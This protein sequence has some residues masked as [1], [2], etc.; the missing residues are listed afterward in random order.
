MKRLHF[1]TKQ[2][3][4]SL[5]EVLLSLGIIAIVLVMVIKYFFVANRNDK[6]STVRQQ[7]GEV[8]SAIESW[9]SGHTAYGDT[10]SLSIG[11]LSDQ[12]FFSKLK[13]NA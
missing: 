5:L 6:I 10:L 8:V 3:G 9:Q 1:S 11:T 13:L 4:I 2:Q 12:G 7:I